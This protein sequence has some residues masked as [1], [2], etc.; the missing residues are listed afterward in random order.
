[1]G[2]ISWVNFH[3]L[4]QEALFSQHCC[5]PPPQRSLKLIF[6]CR[7]QLLPLQHLNP[8][9]AR[10]GGVSSPLF[11]TLSLTSDRYKR[12]AKALHS[13]G[14]QS[15]AGK[16]T[17]RSLSPKPGHTSRSPREL[18][19]SWRDSDSVGPTWSLTIWFLTRAPD[20][21]DGANTYDRQVDKGKHCIM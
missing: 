16:S 6:Q 8:E 21:S 4:V 17:Q 11:W 7:S 19:D 12:T 20:D 5:Q 1:M 9:M 13:T 3:V 18:A 2:I 10:D 15:K 14:L